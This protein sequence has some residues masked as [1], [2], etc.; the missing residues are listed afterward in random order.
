MAGRSPRSS[1]AWE[2]A[3][4]TACS[5]ISPI[6]EVPKRCFRMVSGTLPGRKPGMRTC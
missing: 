4:L 6:T 3:S 1:I 5:T 2:D